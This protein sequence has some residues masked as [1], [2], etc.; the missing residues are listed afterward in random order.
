MN[1]GIINFYGLRDLDGL[2]SGLHRIEML[3][4]IEFYE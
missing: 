1:N 3:H 2:L 4:G